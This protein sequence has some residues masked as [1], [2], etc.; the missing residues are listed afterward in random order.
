M[1]ACVGSHQWGQL[2]LG[3]VAAGAGHEQLDA[4]RVQQVVVHA[5][6]VGQQAA[7]RLSTHNTHST[8]TAL[9]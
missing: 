3:E 7:A 2:V 4:G 1:K 5:V 9:S 6:G 8:V